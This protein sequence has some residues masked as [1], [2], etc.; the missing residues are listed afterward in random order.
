MLGVCLG[1]LTNNK[2][3]TILTT[4]LQVTYPLEL[5]P[6]LVRRSSTGW[7]SA[8]V[9]TNCQI[10]TWRSW[11]RVTVDKGSKS[12]VQWNRTFLLVKSFK[13]LPRSLDES[14]GPR[15]IKLSFS[16][17]DII[18]EGKSIGPDKKKSL[19]KSS[20]FGESNHK[21]RSKV[22]HFFV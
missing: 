13:L 5:T 14:P 6:T 21:L 18:L 12:R 10:W 19:K 8:H 7:T 20:W 9:G 2:P 16:L 15:Q 17:H 1:S 4:N 3:T 11:F 22:A